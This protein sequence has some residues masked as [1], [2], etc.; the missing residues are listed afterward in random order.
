MRTLRE[1]DMRDPREIYPG[2]PIS[3]ILNRLHQQN[4]SSQIDQ[5]F[6]VAAP[7]PGWLG[8]GLL[9]AI[10]VFGVGMFTLNRLIDSGLFG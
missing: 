2:E 9:I 5:R 10:P 3:S 1:G 6:P 8:W 7:L 4:S